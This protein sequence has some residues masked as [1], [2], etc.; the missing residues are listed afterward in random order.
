[1]VEFAVRVRVGL[2]Q[3]PVHPAGPSG[4]PEIRLHPGRAAGHRFGP[5]QTGMIRFD[6]LRSDPARSDLTRFR[7][8][9]G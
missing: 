5:I 6:L 2:G 4:A 7:R 3:H 1:M 8:A 9:G